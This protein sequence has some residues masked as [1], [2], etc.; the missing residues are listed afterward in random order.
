[1]GDKL[2]SK[3]YFL[4]TLEP[5]KFINIYDLYNNFIKEYGQIDRIAFYCECE[6]LDRNFKNITKI[7]RDKIIYLM[8]VTDTTIAEKEPRYHRHVLTDGFSHFTLLDR[9]S[10]MAKSDNDSHRYYIQDMNKTFDENGDKLQHYIV[11]SRN[12]KLLEDF[13][14]LNDIDPELKNK[15]GETV[16]DIINQ[17]DR[18]TGDK[19]L[20]LIIES[21][22]Y[23]MQDC[24]YSTNK[25]ISLMRENN[26]LK[27]LLNVKCN[28]KVN[29]NMK[30]E[31]NKLKFYNAIPYILLI[32]YLYFCLF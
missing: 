12:P 29:E 7:V 16:Y 5:N 23:N 17:M 27:A 22:N 10:Y 8:F 24:S 11:R 26:E 6:I 9:L 3:I 18:N 4:L 19:M 21:Q 2:D 31:V 15:N 30:R 25:I 13:L 14:S 20:R 32:L 1:M 28:C